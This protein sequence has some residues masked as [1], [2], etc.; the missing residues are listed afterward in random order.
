MSATQKQG[1]VKKTT[2]TEAEVTEV[3][4][5][6]ATCNAHEDLNLSIS[7]DALR[8]RPGDSVNDFLYYEDGSLLG[9]LDLDSLGRVEK[10][11]TGMVYPNN[12]RQGIFR[13]LFEAAKTECGQR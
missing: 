13:M 4:Q 3:A 9:Y 10:E 6:L 12:R 7:L 2:L 1:L 11:C 5:L 8:N